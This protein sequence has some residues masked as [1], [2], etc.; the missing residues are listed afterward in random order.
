ME[1][2]NYIKP[3][4][5]LHNYQTET[6]IFLAAKHEKTIMACSYLN[7]FKYFLHFELLANNIIKM[8]VFI[9]IP[10]TIVIRNRKMVWKGHIWWYFFRELE[11]PNIWGGCTE[12]TP[13]Q[14]KVVAGFSEELL[15]ENNFW[16]YFIQFLLLWLVP[17]LLRLFWRLVQGHWSCTP[18]P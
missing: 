15:S 12:N 2:R 18:T 9:K 8:K 5:Y 13:Q 3:G 7:F 6:P 16:D 17:M 10:G 4:I 11:I 14:W 1:L